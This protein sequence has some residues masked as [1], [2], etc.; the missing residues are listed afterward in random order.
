MWTDPI[1]E[2]IHARRVIAL[3]E[4]NG[5]LQRYADALNLRFDAAVRN[6]DVLKTPSDA[7]RKRNAPR[8]R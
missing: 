8:A 3:A 5:D 1:V 6:G 4:H 7:E 2:E